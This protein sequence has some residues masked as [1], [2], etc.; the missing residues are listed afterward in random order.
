MWWNTEINVE[1]YERKA[2]LGG[3]FRG[4][5]VIRAKGSKRRVETDILPD[6]QSAGRAI[7]DKAVEPELK[8]K[9]FGI[10]HYRGKPFKK[11][12]FVA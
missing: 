10:G 5:A 1:A 3:G 12:Y 6:R 9:R 2:E 4:V 11:N 7:F 8:D